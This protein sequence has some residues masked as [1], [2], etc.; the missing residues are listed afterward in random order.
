MPEEA[1]ETRSVSF[2]GVLRLTSY[3]QTDLTDQTDYIKHQVDAAMENNNNK[4]I[5]DL[6]KKDL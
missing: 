5:L 6:E 1:R 2:S 4:E 3:T